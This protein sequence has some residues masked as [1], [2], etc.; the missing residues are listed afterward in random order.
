MRSLGRTTPA[1]EHWQQEVATF[2]ANAQNGFQPACSSTLIR[3]TS[4]PV[5]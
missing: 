1:A 5:P 3:P 4:T 2:L